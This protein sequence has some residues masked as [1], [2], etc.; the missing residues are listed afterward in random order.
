L[1]SLKEAAAD[2][3]DIDSTQEAVVENSYIDVEDDSL[4][5]KS[6]LDALGRAYGRPSKNVVFRNSHLGR[7][8]GLTIGSEGSGGVYN[9]TYENLTLNGT[10]CGVHI[11]SRPSRGGVMDG[12]YYRNIR[13]HNVYQLV[14]V[15]MG[16]DC[17]SNASG[18]CSD[19]TRPQ[20]NNLVM[21]NITFTAD[22]HLLNHTPPLKNIWGGIAGEV[23]GGLS[24]IENVTMRDVR[25]EFPSS[26]STCAHVKNGRCEGSTTHCPPCFNQSA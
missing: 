25:I 13:A 3:I 18:F 16:G 2:G 26:W 22:E 24:G 14:S 15:S 7:G 6:G 23:A 20:L 8:G 4:C 5:V 21:D 17:V 10:S 1:R 9:I 12:I 19:A 11:K